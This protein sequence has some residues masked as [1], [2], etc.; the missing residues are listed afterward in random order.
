MART[1][2]YQTVADGFFLFSFLAYTCHLGRHCPRRSTHGSLFANEKVKKFFCNVMGSRR[3]VVAV[4]LPAKH[5]FKAVWE[6]ASVFGS[7][8]SKMYSVTPANTTGGEA[9]GRFTI[10]ASKRDFRLFS[11][12]IMWSE[13]QLNKAKPPLQAN[14]TECWIRLSIPVLPVVEFHQT[15]LPRGLI[16]QLSRTKPLL[17][18]CYPG[19]LF[20]N[21]K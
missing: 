7:Y 13:L 16:V 3:E 9:A 5:A 1:L 4:W 15:P 20:W 6:S 19:T 10:T 21:S 12:N 14:R 2:R 11:S 17:L 8:Y 18:P